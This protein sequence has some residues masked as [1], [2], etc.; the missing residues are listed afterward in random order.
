[1]QETILVNFPPKVIFVS[2]K[3]LK[4][5]GLVRTVLIKFVKKDTQKVTPS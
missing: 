1:M 3:E 5:H 2:L 4:S